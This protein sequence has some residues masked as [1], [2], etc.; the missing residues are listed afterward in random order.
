MAADDFEASPAF[1]KRWGFAG[2]SVVRVSQAF[3]YM[4]Y[5]HYLG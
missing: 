2:L 4:L 5:M 3:D 1:V